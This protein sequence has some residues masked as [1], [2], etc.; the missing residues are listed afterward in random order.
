MV[1]QFLNFTKRVPAGT[2]IF[3]LGSMIMERHGGSVRDLTLYKDEVF[4]RNLL[5]D[6]MLRLCDV[7]FSDAAADADRVIYYDFA[8]RKND[9]PLLLNPPNNLKIEAVQRAEADAKARK[10]AKLAEL[11]QSATQPSLP[12]GSIRSVPSASGL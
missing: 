3:E 4:P 7:E 11:K 6:Q 12:A 5:C 8:P 9:C 10:A 2:R 1:W